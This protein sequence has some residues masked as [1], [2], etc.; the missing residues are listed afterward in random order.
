MCHWKKK[1]TGGGGRDGWKEHKGGASEAV[2]LFRKGGALGAWKEI[3]A[4]LD[5]EEP[6]K[7]KAV[8]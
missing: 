2:V 7:S 3:T 5:S 4:L 6:G 1:Q 8:I